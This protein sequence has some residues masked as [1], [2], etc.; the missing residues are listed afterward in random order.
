MTDSMLGFMFKKNQ[1]TL[2]EKKS[3]DPPSPLPHA[4]VL[5]NVR[6]PQFVL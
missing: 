4:A 2:Q 1:E 6:Q 3:R 5:A